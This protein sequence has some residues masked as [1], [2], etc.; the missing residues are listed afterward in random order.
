[1]IAVAMVTNMMAMMVAMMIRMLQV[2]IASPGSALASFLV[3]GDFGF[4]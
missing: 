1:M 2:M 3:L 4:F